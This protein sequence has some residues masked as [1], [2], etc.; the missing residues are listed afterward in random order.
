M[1]LDSFI[2]DPANK[3]LT[4]II[5]DS[6]NYRCLYDGIYRFLW[7]AWSFNGVKE[8]VE[9]HMAALR[10]LPK[11]IAWPAYRIPS[12]GAKPTEG[13]GEEVLPA[14][15]EKETSLQDITAFCA[16]TIRLLDVLFEQPRHYLIGCDKL[17]GNNLRGMIRGL[18][19]L[20]I[21]GV[22]DPDEAKVLRKLLEALVDVD[23]IPGE[24]HNFMHEVPL[25]HYRLPLIGPN[26]VMITIWT[27][28]LTSFN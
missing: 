24:L 18:C 19:D 6:I 15:L 2:S 4:L 14:S 28:L 22:P 23:V 21:K 26:A 7:I 17:S 10:V 25:P 16:E 11:F 8:H 27:L 12:R 9:K 1:S 13:H 5:S 3:L 20:A